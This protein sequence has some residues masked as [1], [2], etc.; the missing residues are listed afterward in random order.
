MRSGGDA[1]EVSEF[2]VTKKAFLAPVRYA[3]P[4]HGVLSLRKKLKIQRL[5][6]MGGRFVSFGGGTEQA[7]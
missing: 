1:G 6:C 2:E 7:I 5:F 4:S 3:S